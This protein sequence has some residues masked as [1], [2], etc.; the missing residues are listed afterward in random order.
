MRVNPI[1]VIAAMLLFMLSSHAQDS[2]RYR[3]LFKDTSF[4]PSKNITAGAITG[5][6]QSA[7]RADRNTKSFVV[8][9]FENI[10]GEQEK[11]QLKLAGIELLDYIPNNAYSATV[12]GSLNSQALAQLKARAVIEMSPALKMQPALL[13][14]NYPAWA[15]KVPG[16]IDVWIS[17]PK[18]YSFETVSN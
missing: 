11:Q 14:G 7:L 15:T 9:Q 5:V 18:S 12:T 3:I 8:I 1:P 4:I 2:S 6:S 17:F 10:P 16:T 13:A